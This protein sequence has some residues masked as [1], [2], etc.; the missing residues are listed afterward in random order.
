VTDTT[1]CARF[2]QVWKGIY[3][4]T[5]SRFPYA[6][7]SLALTISD[8]LTLPVTLQRLKF[9]PTE[10]GVNNLSLVASWTYPRNTITTLLDNF[11]SGSFTTNQWTVSGGTNWQ[12][13][14]STGNPAPSAF[15]NYSPV[16]A[17]YDQYLTSRSLAGS[18]AGHMVLLYDIFLD[19]YLSSTL[20]SMKVEKWDGIN[21]SVLHSFDNAGGS[22]PWMSFTDD[23]SN[24]AHNPGF[25]IRFHAGGANSYNI[26]GWYI[27]NVKIRSTGDPLRD[28]CVMG[29][30]CYLDGVLI[31]TAP[32]TSLTIPPELVVYGQTYEVCVRAVY[33]NGLSEPVCTTFT[34]HYHYPP[35]NLS[36]SYVPEVVTLAWDP[37]S[38][39]TGLTGYNIYRFGTL[40][41]SS[42]VT[43]LSYSDTVVS[44]GYLSYQVSAV[45]G[46]AES[47]K[48]GPAGILTI[49]NQRV[50]D[51]TVVTGDEN[52]CYHAIQTITVAGNG[53]IFEVQNGGSVTMIAG[54]NIFYYP[55]TKV[56]SGGY[57]WGYIA[58]SG[59]FCT[60]PYNHRPVT[61]NTG[62]P[63]PAGRQPLSFRIYPNP[64]HDRFLLEPAGTAA[65]ETCVADLYTIRGESVAHRLLTG[66]LRYTFSLADQPPGIYLIRVI[67][68]ARSETVKIIKN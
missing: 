9:P 58:P 54:G 42:P 21:W 22:I 51:S 44:F 40:I 24:L 4:L 2:P 65:G 68:G 3:T 43:A 28:P 17:N 57:L 8:S 52:R 33:S 23:I 18:H 25:N 15:F 53:K 55:G 50:I 62:D 61:M 60:N 36:T 27:D 5:V 49:P 20:E 37:P 14:T 1:G 56:D 31:G 32:D 11:S 12:I 19:N 59:P 41:N 30:N 26:D 67:S 35:R 47:L 29:I 48:A 10:P 66:A 34:S 38:N 6:T 13:G 63:A 64:T 46:A 16:V 7:A 45:Y 39:P